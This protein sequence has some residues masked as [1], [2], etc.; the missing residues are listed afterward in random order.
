M[1]SRLAQLH[2][3][4]SAEVNDTK[5]ENDRGNLANWEIVAT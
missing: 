3:D 1:E 4:L 5:T 2:N